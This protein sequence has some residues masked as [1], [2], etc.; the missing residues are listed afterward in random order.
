M[1]EKALPIVAVEQCPEPE[2]LVEI[3]DE[4]NFDDVF[5]DIPETI[6]PTET[7]ILALEKSPNLQFTSHV[8]M[9]STCQ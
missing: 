7:E 5:E 8:S 1:S 4:P 6:I 2:N 9:S 3:F